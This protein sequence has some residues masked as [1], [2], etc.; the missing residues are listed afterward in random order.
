MA[1]TYVAFVASNI[2]FCS[3]NCMPKHMFA[4]SYNHSHK[5]YVFLA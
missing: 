4:Y 5:I 1:R 2:N 3:A